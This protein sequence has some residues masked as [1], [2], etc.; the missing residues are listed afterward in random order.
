MKA[1]NVKENITE[2]YKMIHSLGGV[3][4]WTVTV[5]GNK[6]KSVKSEGCTINMF[7]VQTFYPGFRWKFLK[8]Q[9][10]L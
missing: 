7:K 4:T 1:R 10:Q 9:T 6:C 2:K 8:R 3:P 5:A